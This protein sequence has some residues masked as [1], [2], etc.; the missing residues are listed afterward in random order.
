MTRRRSFRGRRSR[1]FSRRRRITR[2]PRRRT[3]GNIGFSRFTSL[4]REIVPQMLKVTLPYSA[5]VTITLNSDLPLYK[6]FYDFKANGLYDPN[7]TGFGHQPYGFDQWSALYRT[8]HV[9]SSSVS[10]VFRYARSELASAG[11]SNLN[12]TAFISLQRSNQASDYIASSRSAKLENPSSVFSTLGNPQASNSL[13]TLKYNYNADRF[14]NQ[15]GLDEDKLEAETGADPVQVASYLIGCH[16]SPLDISRVDY[17]EATI[18]IKY[19]VAFRHP[20]ILTQ[21]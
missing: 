2:R 9:I 1:R 10:V 12:V 15:D 5:V 18:L 8:Y 11:F 14:W 7:T 16:S 21:S 3:R 17:V 4:N 6:Q 19:R 13:K 20:L